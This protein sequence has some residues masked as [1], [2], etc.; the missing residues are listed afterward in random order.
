VVIGEKVDGLKEENGVE[1]KVDRYGRQKR[2][3]EFGSISKSDTAHDLYD[4]HWD[5]EC[6]IALHNIVMCQAS[7]GGYISEP[8]WTGESSLGNTHP[9]K[10]DG[11]DG[12]GN[13][14]HTSYRNWYYYQAI[15]P[16]SCDYWG[17]MC[18]ENTCIHDTEANNP[19]PGEWCSGDYADFW[20]PK[21]VYVPG[22]SYITI[23][24][25]LNPY[26]LPESCNEWTA[27]VFADYGDLC[28]CGE[29][30]TDV[31]FG[32]WLDNTFGEYCNVKQCMNCQPK[33]WYLDYKNEVCNPPMLG[34]REWRRGGII[35]K[36]RR[37]RR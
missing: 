37:G 36:G 25:G 2:M 21:T 26:W 33:Q 11:C 10:V 3:N 9:P 6:A 4:D 29:N 12:W 8:H 24:Y 7:S 1:D 28:E 22:Q 17:Y 20:E 15:W 31:S 18:S 27:T 35:K 19:C 34:S 23:D 14:T 5:L 30:W 32:Y 13:G 16:E